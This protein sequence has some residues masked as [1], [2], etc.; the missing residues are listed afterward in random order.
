MW[1][2]VKPN[3]GELYHYGIKGQRWGQRN[4]QYENGKLTP[5]GEARYRKQGTLSRRGEGLGTGPVGKGS[6][7]QNTQLQNAKSN[8]QS[9]RKAS[10]EYHTIK[11]TTH[12]I[13][14]L[15]R[16]GGASSNTGN[17]RTS[18][19]YGYTKSSEK[20]GHYTVY[21]P[22]SER[23]YDVDLSDED[24][25]HMSQ[26]ELE[27]YINLK[28]TAMKANE[29]LENDPEYKKQEVKNKADRTVVKIQNAVQKASVAVSKAVSNL[30]K[31]VSS[32]ASTVSSKVA[33]ALDRV[34]SKVL[35]LFKKR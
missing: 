13:E 26:E 4:Y 8:A 30:N 14:S 3:G 19:G 17:G 9:R 29:K 6:R 25:S 20:E 32:T 2:K 23:L 31:T 24:T 7:P 21:D 16:S 33:S 18:Q 10:V 28:V 35:G 22:E 34:G 15:T 1:V 27:N 5:E 12:K 11:D